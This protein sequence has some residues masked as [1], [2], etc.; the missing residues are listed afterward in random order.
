[1]I[2]PGICTP[3]TDTNTGSPAI[4]VTSK[5]IKVLNVVLCVSFLG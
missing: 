4:L 2:S 1:M 3:K 5:L